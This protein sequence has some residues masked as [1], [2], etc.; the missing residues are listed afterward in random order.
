MTKPVSEEDGWKQAAGETEAATRPRA[1]EGLHV[2]VDFL[3]PGLWRKVVRQLNGSGSACITELSCIRKNQNSITRWYGCQ[4]SHGTESEPFGEPFWLLFPG[5]RQP[6][7]C[8]MTVFR[9]VVLTR[10]FD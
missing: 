6:F 10:L 8:L 3:Q 7:R 5:N 1:D 2:T 4:A 9:P